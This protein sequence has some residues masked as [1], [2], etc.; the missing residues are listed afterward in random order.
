MDEQLVVGHEPAATTTQRTFA[1]LYVNPLARILDQ[2]NINNYWRE[3]PRGVFD[4]DPDKTLQLLVDFK[5]DG[6]ECD[7]KDTFA[8]WGDCH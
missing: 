8:S 1:A 2:V 3:S 5:T 6:E 4:M 7:N